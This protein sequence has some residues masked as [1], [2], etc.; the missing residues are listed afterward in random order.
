VLQEISSYHLEFQPSVGKGVRGN[1]SPEASADNSR[2]FRQRADDPI[3]EITQ[4]D[5][6]AF[7]NKLVPK[8]AA[9]TANH[10]LKALKMLFKSARRDGVIVENSAE[11]VDTIRQRTTTPKRGFNIDEVRAILNVADDEWRS[12]VLFGLYTG[13]RLSDIAS[14][15]WGNI[16]LP[17]GDFRLVT[18]K[19][20]KTMILPIAAPLLWNRR[21][22]VCPT[23]DEEK[24]LT[25]AI[26]PCSLRNCSL[27]VRAVSGA[28][29]G[30]R[31]LRQ[32]L[33]WNPLVWSALPGFVSKPATPGG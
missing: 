30:L 1:S 24:R 33:C 11:F 21:L 13:Q 4:Q 23:C 16:D 19:T 3:G 5:I 32:I 20:G 18:R 27:H 8:V 17:G 28:W 31:Y 25:P 10:D 2:P 9:K 29:L 7:R 15:R 6:V 26:R 22:R 12:M 14:V